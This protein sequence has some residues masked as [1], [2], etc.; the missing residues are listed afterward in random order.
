MDTFFKQNYEKNIRDD[1]LS[2]CK[3]KVGCGLEKKRY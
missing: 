2:S 1:L 3:A